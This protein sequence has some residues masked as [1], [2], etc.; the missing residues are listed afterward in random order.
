MILSITPDQLHIVVPR[1]RVEKHLD[2]R[3]AG[4]PQ[5]TVTWTLDGDAISQKVRLE[6]IDEYTVVSKLTV[7]IRNETSGR[8]M[9]QA[10]NAAGKASK[11]TL[12]FTSNSNGLRTRSPNVTYIVHTNVSIGC[13]SLASPARVNSTFVW[14]RVNKQNGQNVTQPV[15]EDQTVFSDNSLLGSSRLR[16]EPIQLSH[17]GVYQCDVTEIGSGKPTMTQRQ[18]VFVRPQPS[19]S[20]SSVPSNPTRSGSLTLHC[21]VTHASNRNIKW[22]KDGRLL[23]EGSRD[24]P[25]SVSFN[26]SMQQNGGCLA[27]ANLDFEHNGNYTCELETGSDVSSAFDLSVQCKCTFTAYNLHTIVIL[28]TQRRLS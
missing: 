4:V 15:V 27:I 21:V 9:C 6:A 14:K 8:Y 2:C 20:I 28:W 26:C 22:Y 3:A 18:Y 7:T 25:Q 1:E 10:S 16:F 23:V 17:E 12:L 13:Y 24:L 11:A 19:I 5:P